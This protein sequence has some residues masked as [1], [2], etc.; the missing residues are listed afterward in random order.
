MKRQS[1]RLFDGKTKKVN[2]V[3]EQQKKNDSSSE[4]ESFPTTFQNF[5][6]L[7]GDDPCLFHFSVSRLLCFEHQQTPTRKIEKD[8]GQKQEQSSTKFQT[9]FFLEQRSNFTS[10]TR[11]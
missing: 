7:S 8:F 10:S 3:Q 5:F 11:Q 6:N 1:T 9:R 2:F 4:I